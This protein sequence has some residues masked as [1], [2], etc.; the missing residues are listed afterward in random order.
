MWYITR[1]NKSKILL[2]FIPKIENHF[3]LKAK[4]LEF[5]NKSDLKLFKERLNERLDEDENRVIIFS[6]F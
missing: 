3:D 6:L 4:V 1:T 2:N 5:K